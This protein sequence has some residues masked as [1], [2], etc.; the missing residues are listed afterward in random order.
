M[1]GFFFLPKGGGGTKDNGI[2]RGSRKGP[3]DN[4]ISRREGGLRPIFGKFTVNLI[5]LNFPGGGG[6]E[7]HPSNGEG[8]T[9][10]SLFSARHTVELTY[11]N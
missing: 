2:S 3:N 7:P 6:S 4:G 11:Q 5:H 1:R 8:V 9:L 10:T